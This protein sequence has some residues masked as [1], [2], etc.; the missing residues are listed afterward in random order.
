MYIIYIMCIQRDRDIRDLHPTNT[1]TI[2]HP[3]RYKGRT[4]W[5]NSVW[6]GGGASLAYA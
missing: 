2:V 1:N 6:Y 3:C 5:R 4:K